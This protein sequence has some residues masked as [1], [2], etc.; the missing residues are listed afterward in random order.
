MTRAGSP[1][2]NGFQNGSIPVIAVEGNR[3]PIS[4]PI[5]LPARRKKVLRRCSS[6][7]S[8]CWMEVAPRSRLSVQSFR[9]R[10][11]PQPEE[12]T[13]T[14]ASCDGFGSP[15]GRQEDSVPSGISTMR[16]SLLPSFEK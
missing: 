15:D 10:R 9:D 13:Q 3:R 6:T 16:S 1:V 12:E 2:K 7:R 5:R 4:R 8:F 11:R 14:L